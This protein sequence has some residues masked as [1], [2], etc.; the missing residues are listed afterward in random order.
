[1]V[2]LGL[3]GLGA[4]GLDH[5]RA[6]A[7]ARRARVVAAC[8]TSGSARKA[9]GEMFPGTEVS[10][11]IGEMLRARPDIRGL[12]MALPHHVYAAVWDEV[13]SFGLPVLKEKPLGRNLA[14][15]LGFL[16]P[17]SGRKVAVKTAI[18]RRHHPS[19]KRLFSLVGRGSGG[20]GVTE[21]SARLHLGKKPGEHG[22]SWR[23]DAALSGGGALL[24]CGY[25]LVDLVT[26]LA[27][28]MEVLSAQLWAGDRPAAADALEDRAVV[29]ARAG[30]TWIRLEIRRDGETVGG[31]VR[32]LEEVR[33]ATTAGEYLADR[34]GVW[35]DGARV[36][37]CGREWDEALSAQLDSF[38]DD[39]LRGSF[40]DFLVWEQAPV[41]RV[42][43][44]AYSMAR[45]LAPIAG[46]GR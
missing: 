20:P 4:Q 45:E 41:M 37:A 7:G 5:L 12:V 10:G 16:S 6:S 1:M 34:S 40:D 42:I 31:E 27:G 23:G 36:M 2:N 17:P 28:P 22:R 25:H 9:A 15:A 19:Y 33:L 18:Q 24:D 11:S 13:E 14:E 38:A 46:D 26:F 32:K 29:S 3:A 21:I 30:R 44:R 35:R 8:D 39:I 43:A